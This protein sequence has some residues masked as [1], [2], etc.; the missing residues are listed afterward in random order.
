MVD[1]RVCT[2]I[3]NS[4]IVK[5]TEYQG[6]SKLTPGTSVCYDVIP[7]NKQSIF[8]SENIVQVKKARVKVMGDGSVLNSGIAYFVIPP[9]L[10]GSNE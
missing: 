1:G 5:T 9:K 7:V 6:I 2:Q 3:D 8:P 4:K 10:E